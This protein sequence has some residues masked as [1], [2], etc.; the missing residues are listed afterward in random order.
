MIAFKTSG[1]APGSSLE[2]VCIGDDNCLDGDDG[3]SGTGTV[4]S[5]SLKSGNTRDPTPACVARI[6]SGCVQ[7]LTHTHTNSAPLRFKITSTFSSG[8][9]NCRRFNVELIFFAQLIFGVWVHKLK[10]WKSI[11]KKI[12][13]LHLLRHP[14]QQALRGAPPPCTLSR[15]CVDIVYL[16]LSMQ[17]QWAPLTLTEQI[18][19]QLL[20]VNS[21]SAPHQWKCTLK[22]PSFLRNTLRCMKYRSWIKNCAIDSSSYFLPLVAFSAALV[23]FPDAGSLKL[24]ALITP[25]ATV[26]LMSRTAKRPRGGNSWKDSTHRGFDGTRLTIAAS[27]DLIDLG[28]SS[29]DLP[30]RRSTF[31]LISANLQAIWAVWQSSTGVYPL[32]ISPGWLSTITCA[33]KSAAPLGGL[34]LESPAT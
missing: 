26:C 15:P 2:K 20:L 3:V 12:Y 21:Q 19:R 24:T 14:P 32:E 11:K 5:R 16:N 27:P 23:T 8:S 29:V 30:V 31:S 17:L 34:F 25:T 18:L 7:K 9:K 1:Q 13:A 10:I 6:A 22:S 28:L 4:L 33:V